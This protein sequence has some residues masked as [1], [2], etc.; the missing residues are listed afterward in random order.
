MMVGASML[1]VFATAQAATTVPLHTYGRFFTTDR[2]DLGDS[3][4][5]TEDLLMAISRLE[6]HSIGMTSACK[7]SHEADSAPA[8]MVCASLDGYK[9]ALRA[10]V[11]TVRDRD[12]TIVRLR[13]EVKEAHAQ[14]GSQVPCARAVLEP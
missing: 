14:C 4:M 9:A 7:D 1:F 10:A 5:G 8:G 3:P 13:D 11:A 6:E 2:A 12:A